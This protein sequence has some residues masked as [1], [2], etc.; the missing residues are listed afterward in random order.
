[1]CKIVNFEIV[2]GDALYRSLTFTNEDGTPFALDAYTDILM[3]VRRSPGSPI[4]AIGTMADQN[5]IVSGDDNNV[6]LIE[7]IQIPSDASGAYQYD[8]E[9]VNTRTW[10]NSETNQGH[11]ENVRTTLVRGRIII[12]PQITQEAE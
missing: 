5:F 2:A 4:I 9:F 12:I 10:T 8:I 1:M 3:H 6:L 7:G 11:V